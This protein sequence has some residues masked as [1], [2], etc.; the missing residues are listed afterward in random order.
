MRLGVL[1]VQGASDLHVSALRRLGVDAGA[2]RHVDDLDGLDGLVLPG[3]E[4]TTI[5]MMLEST[6]LADPL[7]EELAAGLPAFG[8]CAGM[9]LL[10]DKI[11]DG[12][13][14]QLCFGVIDIAVRRN[15]WGRQVESFETQL[16]VPAVGSDPVPAVFIRAPGVDSVG[17]GVEVLASHAGRPV[18]CRQGSV[19]VAAFHPELSDDLRLHRLFVESVVPIRATR[20]EN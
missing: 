6:G 18:L 7:G 11:A 13:P 9:I 4:S 14:D 10:A 1:A 12:R 2:V 15:A 20:E 8:T 17:P 16:D 5:S 3:G 19:L